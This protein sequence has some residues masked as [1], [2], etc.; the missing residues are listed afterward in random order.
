MTLFLPKPLSHHAISLGH[1]DGMIDELG[2]IFEHG[3]E[4]AAKDLA[5]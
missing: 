2:N 1:D 5:L 3:L 4:A